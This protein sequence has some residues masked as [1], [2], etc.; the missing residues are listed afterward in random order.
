MDK[1]GSNEPDAFISGIYTRRDWLSCVAFIAQVTL[2]F[3]GTKAASQYPNLVT[4]KHLKENR[5][6]NASLAMSST[7]INRLGCT[8]CKIHLT[9]PC[10]R[11]ALR[12]LLCRDG[13]MPRSCPYSL[14]YEK[15][16][17]PHTQNVGLWKV[18]SAVLA[19][20]STTLLDG[21][22]ENKASLC[23]ALKAVRAGQ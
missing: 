15:D 16:A 8:G 19:A 12:C 18:L 22:K 11:S 4:V 1:A 6:D 10:L 14:P 9:D 3:E 20:A 2:S 7:P 17:C 23:S 5:P 13:T 21:S